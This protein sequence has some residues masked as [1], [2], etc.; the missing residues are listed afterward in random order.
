MVVA[1]AARK[2]AGAES[3]LAKKRAE[4]ELV[5]AEAELVAAQAESA[6]TVKLAQTRR[7]KERI[8]DEIE[9]EKR[10]ERARLADESD[11]EL[12]AIPEGEPRGWPRIIQSDANKPTRPTQVSRL[13]SLAFAT[14]VNQT[15][16]P[17]RPVTFGACPKPKPTP[18]TPPGSSTHSGSQMEDIS[19]KLLVVNTASHCG[20]MLRQ[21]R[22]KE[23]ERFSG[24][25][26]EDLEAFLNQFEQATDAEGATDYMKFIE[27][28]MWVKGT[29]SLAM[30]QFNGEPDAS[31]ALTESKNVLKREFG[32]KLRTARQMLDKLLA[33]PKFT[34]N[35]AEGIQVFT[36]ELESAYRTAER[37]KRASTFSTE[38]T[39][40][41]VLNKKVPFFI[42]LWAKKTFNAQDLDHTMEDSEQNRL[43]F[44]N[45]IKFLRDGNRMNERKTDI[46][47]AGTTAIAP[48]SGPRRA[49]LAATSVETD[50]DNES[51]V[52]AD[53]AATETLRPKTKKGRNFNPRGPRTNEG[54]QRNPRISTQPG[55]CLKCGETHSLDKCR[56]FIRMNDEQKINL[57]RRLGICYLCL[58][59]GHM[60]RD[61]TED[62]SCETCSEKH[63]TLFHRDTRD[64]AEG[65][66][67]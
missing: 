47:K 58:T 22:P 59:Q 27:L 23:A 40:N 44:E 38:E 60:A 67:A 37:T 20:Q 54:A 50:E 52:E 65:N 14:P 6:L 33:G 9:N 55:E 34:A 51:K 5:A 8:L 66:D 16:T 17:S 63:H 32:Q 11:E 29:A 46:T 10:L 43:S 3:A 45:F 39:F 1:Q 13:Q 18:P 53:I 7:E 24:Q 26:G 30:K 64:F 35:D 41:K 25:R 42:H 12:G 4:A 48:T 21:C 2:K 56:Q 36:L 15:E 28:K 61:C 49:K 19:A 57:V 62:I 31:V